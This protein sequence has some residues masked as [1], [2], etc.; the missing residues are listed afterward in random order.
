LGTLNKVP[1]LFDFVLA[2]VKLH[3]AQMITYTAC[4]LADCA[5]VFYRYI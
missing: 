3:S 1:V 5:C 2:Y 4:G